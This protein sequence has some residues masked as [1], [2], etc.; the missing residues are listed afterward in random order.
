MRT[1]LHRCVTD[2]W[3]AEIGPF[4]EMVEREADQAFLSLLDVS[5]SLKQG[6]VTEDPITLQDSPPSVTD[7]RVLTVSPRW[8]EGGGKCSSSHINITSQTDIFHFYKT[9]FFFF[10]LIPNKVIVLIS[11]S[12][13]LRKSPLFEMAAKCVKASFPLR[14]IISLI[15][16]T[17]RKGLESWQYNYKRPISVN[18]SLCSKEPHVEEPGHGQ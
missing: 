13:F 8:E 6:W 18:P 5:L 4:C 2:R 15:K 9:W 3:I 10:F 7:R 12:T 1:V 17:S 16:R 14:K 11:F